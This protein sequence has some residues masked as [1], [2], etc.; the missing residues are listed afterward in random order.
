MYNLRVFKSVRKN[1]FE[2]IRHVSVNG[3]YKPQHIDTNK[4]NIKYTQIDSK[5]RCSSKHWDIQNWSVSDIEKA[6]KKHIVGTWG[7]T[8]VNAGP[9][10]VKSEGVYMYDKDNKQYM[11]WTSQ[12]VCANLGHSAPSAI[13]NAVQKQ[14]KTLP[15]LYSELG[16]CEI[17]SRLSCLIS[18]LLPG[19]FEGV[20][21][22]SSGAEA[23]EVAIRI[24]R[25]Y[26][27]RHKIFTHYRAYHGSTNCTLNATGD[28]RRNFA[29]PEAGFVKMMHPFPN[30]F[31]WKFSNAITEEESVR[32]MLSTVEEQIIHEGPDTIAGFLV[33]SVTG[34]G[35][36]LIAPSSYM[37]GLRR[38]CDKY[39]ILMIADE[40]MVGFCRTGKM[41]GFQHFDILPDIVTAAKGISGS[42][43]P[44]STVV[45][46][47][48][49]KTH[50]EKHPLGWGSTYHAHPVSLACAYECIKYMIEHD[51]LCNV[52]S[53]ECVMI[54]EMNNLIER[55]WCIKQGRALGL[56]G[57]FEITDANGNLIQCA[58]KPTTKETALLKSALQKNGLLCM[59]RSP[60]LH[61]APPLVITKQEL[62]RGFSL[63]KNALQ[64]FER[65]MTK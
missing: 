43:L 35:G 62:R 65:E 5:R 41:W 29:E 52:Q 30:T 38:L 8:N 36:T 6:Q 58:G 27:G 24:A 55:H 59:V 45:M 42:F 28:W 3:S 10:F 12:A 1:V 13:I 50:F 11:D 23:N 47:Q 56:F 40:V 39:G 49:L 63:L 7:V 21:F 37:Q 18:E 14:M 53:L 25:R 20:L 15:I 2:N 31:S 61:C 51:L 22:P 46:R 34:S 32:L 17:R 44:I 54:E 16:M 26:T 57:C 9:L 60:F 64:Q 4:T 33:E 48:P 19:D